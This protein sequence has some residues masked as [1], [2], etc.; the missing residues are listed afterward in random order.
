MDWTPG[1]NH[2]L[3]FWMKT[4]GHVVDNQLAKLF[5]SVFPAL[6]LVRNFR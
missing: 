1:M 4:L 3:L 2:A 5:K 6:I